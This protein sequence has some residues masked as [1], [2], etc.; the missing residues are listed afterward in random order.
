MKRLM[1]L[2]VLLTGCDPTIQC[3]YT[4]SREPGLSKPWFSLR[5]RTGRGREDVYGA[6]FETQED[7]DKFVKSHNLNMCGTK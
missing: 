7:L 1:L 3:W 4:V 5:G 2:A 6:S